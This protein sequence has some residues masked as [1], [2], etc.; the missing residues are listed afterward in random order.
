MHIG[1][2]VEVSRN[3]VLLHGSAGGLDD[4]LLMIAAVGGLALACFAVYVFRLD[5]RKPA[6]DPKADGDA[7][8]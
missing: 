2:L 7:P 1:S 6:A 3:L 8:D 5:A 4:S